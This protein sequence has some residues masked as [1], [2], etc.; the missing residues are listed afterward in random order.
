[1]LPAPTCNGANRCSKSQQASARSR[2]KAL[3]SWCF[4]VSNKKHPKT[5]I[6]P[7]LFGVNERSFRCW[8][9][10]CAWGFTC[11]EVGILCL[12]A[13]FGGGDSGRCISWRDSFK[14]H[15]ARW[16]LDDII[17]WTW[18]VCILCINKKTYCIHVYICY[19][20]IVWLHKQ[21]RI[22]KCMYTWYVFRT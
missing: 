18:M 4:L 17:S 5:M 10:S 14:Y 13:R 11:C 3:V 2:L 19:I 8:N 20:Y 12:R 1:M 15:Q 21:L 7:D 9:L 16:S 22:C 6:A